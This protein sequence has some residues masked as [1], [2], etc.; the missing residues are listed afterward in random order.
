MMLIFIY[1]AAY[2]TWLPFEY[3]FPSIFDTWFVASRCVIFIMRL[4][5][6][7]HN[8]RANIP[9]KLNAPDDYF[10]NDK[11]FLTQSQKWINQT[12]FLRIS[13]SLFNWLIMMITEN[14]YFA[15]KLFI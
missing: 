2:I 8:S 14:F 4:W 6:L 1:M 3:P 10:P 15:E 9:M 5:L 7:V 12:N 13:L 11:T